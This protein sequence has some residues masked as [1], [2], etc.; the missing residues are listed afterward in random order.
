MTRVVTGA[1]ASIGDVAALIRDPDTPAI[2]ATH[3]NPDGDAIGSLLA[4]GR[5]LRA[6]GRDVVLWH[7]EIPPVPVD[8]AFLLRPGEEVVTELPPDAA[9]RTMFALDCA[10]AGRLSTSVPVGDLAGRVVNIDHHH[11]NGRY[12]DLNLVDAGRSSTAELIVAILDAAD[13]P[14]TAD[15]AEPLHVGIVTDTGRLSYS[16]TTAATLRAD[17]RLVE[18][19]IDVAAIAR[20]LYENVDFASVTLTG[21]ALSRARRLLDGRLVVTVLHDEDFHAAGTSDADGVAELL[22]GVRGAEVGALVRTTEEG[23]RASLRAASD[24]VDVSRIARLEGGGGHP[25]AAG[26]RSHRDP[27]AFLAWLSQQVADQLDV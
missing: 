17:A 26:V 3:Q 24:R 18:T 9:D 8:L 4:L 25:A 21:I 1:D 22:R 10:T 23:V 14:L 15:V 27:E 2:V 12:G 13:I 6:L 7:P 19:G 11:D 16:N 20:A 5:V